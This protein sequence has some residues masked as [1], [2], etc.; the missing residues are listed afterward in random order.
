MVF[1]GF[2]KP[3]CRANPPIRNNLA[4]RG[5]IARI[6]DVKAMRKIMLVALPVQK[7]RHPVSRFLIQSQVCPQRAFGVFARAPGYP[8]VPIARFPRT[9]QSDLQHQS[10]DPPW[11][12]EEWKT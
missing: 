8:T 5:H 6:K 11:H 12:I 7:S 4:D 3:N 1:H 9:Y 2:C 10:A